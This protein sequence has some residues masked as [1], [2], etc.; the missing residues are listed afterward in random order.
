MELWLEF[1]LWEGKWEK[2]NEFAT[3]AVS[4][5]DGRRYGI[6][7]WTYQF[8]QT[9][10]KED[11]ENKQSLQGIYQIP[12]D[13]FVRELT[14]ECVEASIKDLLKKGSLEE[15]LNPSVF[16]IQYKAPWVDIAD[17]PSG[18]KYLKAE[19]LRELAPEHELT[20]QD[21]EVLAKRE[22]NDDVL[23][24]LSDGR[25]AVVHLTWSSKKEVLPYPKTQMYFNK[26]EFWKHKLKSDVEA[27]NQ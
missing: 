19:L 8:L 24:G 14:R 1:E 6:N 3:I 25:L 26:K 15:V 10:V 13:L 11:I 27:Y 12:P 20:G 23:I 18:G 7:V 4:L 16:G 2:E 9:A 22:D 17:L 21:L 5:P